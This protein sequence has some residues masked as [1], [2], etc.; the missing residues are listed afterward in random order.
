MTP[1]DTLRVA[2]VGDAQISPDGTM[3]CY[4]VA[5]VEGNATRTSLW[6]A[7]HA[8]ERV[9]GPQPRRVPREVLGGEWNVSRPRWSP[10]GR[11]LALLATRG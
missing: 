11:R 5:A 8:D 2:S 6:C 3:T 1:A 9:I 7:Q 4:T 10:D